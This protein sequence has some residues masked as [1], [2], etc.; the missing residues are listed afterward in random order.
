MPDVTIINGRLITLAGPD[1]PR[2][3][4][5]MSELAEIESGWI[6]IE[7]GR[8]H[9]M[10]EGS[11]P[12]D[13]DSDVVLDLDGRLVLPTWV[14]C[15]THACWAG[16]RLDEWE[17]MLSGVNY[18]EILEAGGGI[19]STVHAVRA[20]S[21]D[22]LTESLFG[23]L[24]RLQSCG[25]GAIEVKSG[26][27]LTTESELKM[28]RAIHEASQDVDTQVV[29]T[30]LGAHAI[31]DEQPDFID[32]VIEE[33]LPTVT[34]EFPGITC[35]AYLEEGAWSL[36]QTRR[37][38]E[39]A[40]SLGCPLRLHTDQFNSLGGVPMA[41]ELGARSVDHLEAITEADIRTLGGSETLGVLLPASG[42]HVDQRYAPG[43]DLIDG[44]AAIAIAT[45]CNPGSAPTYSMP[46]TMALA[47]RRC[48]LSPA[49]AITA[50]TW[51][52]AC[53]LG[54]EGDV[55]SLEVGKRG[56]LQV[57]DERDAR[58]IVWSFGN[59]PPPIVLLEGRPVQ[60]LAE[61]DSAG[62]GEGEG[63]G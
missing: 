43:R 21:Q 61:S 42:F 25:T 57:L 11:P 9:G 47:C 1:G 48:G 34:D 50:A 14:D 32:Y 52:A 3:G 37:L 23:R 10:G 16:S 8:I 18:T 36:A 39:Q 33:V 51:N 15:H 7:D 53:V 13:M 12:Q 4:E 24:G 35:D 45:N 38:F 59:P 5:A 20:A 27:G 6:A 2:R 17:A 63:D 30:F 56:D 55:G 62:E 41:V 22:E 60:F 26:Y 28:L 49:E 40:R 54:I 46:M 19:L 29:G 44:G 58:S 31:D